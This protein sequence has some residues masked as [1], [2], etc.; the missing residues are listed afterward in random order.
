MD[1][2]QLIRVDVRYLLVQVECKSHSCWIS[3]YLL[4]AL[5]VFLSFFLII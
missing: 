1:R 5:T 3:T 4:F 2:Q